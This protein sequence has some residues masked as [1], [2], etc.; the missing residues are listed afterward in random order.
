MTGG[1]GPTWICDFPGHAS[2]YAAGHR[3]ADAAAEC[4]SAGLGTPS[5]IRYA[6]YIASPDPVPAAP[7]PPDPDAI[8]KPSKRS[9]RRAELVLTIYGL[10]RADFPIGSILKPAEAAARL[11]SASALRDFLANVGTAIQHLNEDAK[12]IDR[13]IENQAKA[14]I[15]A[16]KE[17]N[18]RRIGKWK[19]AEVYAERK[20]RYRQHAKRLRKRVGYHKAIAELAA[21]IDGLLPRHELAA[22]NFRAVL[23][24][25]GLGMDDVESLVNRYRRINT[26]KL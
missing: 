21:S 8:P 6:G 1:N 26:P 13:V 17:K 11:P 19:A 16:A 7:P 14:W 20:I 9:G 23:A 12:I 2:A 24:D 3:P 15:A 25:S 22:E 18:A 10:L 5:A 4:K